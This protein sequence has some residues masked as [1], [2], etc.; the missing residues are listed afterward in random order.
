VV[1]IEAVSSVYASEPVGYRNQPEF[2]NLVV[3]VRTDMA[4]ESLL[5][6]T[7]AIEVRVGRRATFPQGPRVLDIDILLFDDRLCDRPGLRIPHPRMT[8]RA[9]VLRPLLELDPD[10]ALPGTGL[11]L[12]ERLET[13]KFEATRRL[14]PGSELLPRT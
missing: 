7:Q 1:S 5:R 13:G 2:W 6:E 12:S 9:F 10:L 8:E 14:F 11:R 3:R 4:P